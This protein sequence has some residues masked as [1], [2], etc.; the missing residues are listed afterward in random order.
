MYKLTNHI[1]A[2]IWLDAE[3]GVAVEKKDLGKVAHIKSEA[4]RLLKEAKEKDL[5]NGNGLS[6]LESLAY[7]IINYNIK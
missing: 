5:Y 6:T 7:D 4:E 2:L 1:Y 3:L